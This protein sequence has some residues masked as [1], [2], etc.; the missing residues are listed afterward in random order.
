MG[1]NST[2]LGASANVFMVTLSEKLAKE[3]GDHSLAIT[4]GLWFR[5]STPVMLATLVICTIVLA[6]FCDFFSHPI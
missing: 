4:P 3:T 6:L 1:R 5:K 2:H